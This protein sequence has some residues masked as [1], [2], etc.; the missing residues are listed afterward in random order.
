[1]HVWPYIYITYTRRCTIYSN[2]YIYMR[3]HA[4]TCIT[5]FILAHVPHTWIIMK[6]SA[7]MQIDQMHACASITRNCNACGANEYMRM[8]CTWCMGMHICVF[9]HACDV[10]YKFMRAYY[11]NTCDACS[12]MH[13]L[14]HVHAR[15]RYIC[16]YATHVHVRMW[17]MHDSCDAFSC[18]WYMRDTCPMI[19]VRIYMCDACVCM[20]EIHA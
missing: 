14:L 5:W 12:C 13:Y 20:H 6:R 9:M 18:M 7:Y 16:M 17:C 3:M 11:F 4:W 8:W 15:M 10:W 1:M 2:I 19:H